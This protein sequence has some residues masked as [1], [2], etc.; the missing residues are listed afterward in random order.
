MINKKE[1]GIIIA[2][3]LILAFS[4][5]FLESMSLFLYALLGVFIIIVV[6]IIGKKIAAYYFESEIE[7]DFWGLKRYGFK[8]NWK[9]KRPLQIGAFLPIISKIFF[10]P[11]KNFV[12]MASLVF[13]VKPKTY[14]AARRHGLYNFSEM[15]EDHIGIIAAVGILVNIFFAVAGYLIGFVEFAKLN[16]YFAF[17]NILP[18]SDL[19]GN[20][21]F[22]GSIILW[23]L[24]A[25]FVLIGLFCVV[26][27]I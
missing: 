18:I 19:D 9:F 3:S 21:I 23:S 1:I 8:P 22:F 17:F 5:T 15:T 13:E 20:K 25:A 7:I 26:F 14:R 6:N 11:L 12:W 24:L 16:L 2:S 27:I 10:Y 4:I